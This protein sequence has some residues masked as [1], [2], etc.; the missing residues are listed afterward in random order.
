MIKA[1]IFDLDQTLIDS[2]IA[3]ANRKRRDWQTVYSQIPAFG[4]YDGFID[5]FD[6]ITN[7][8][9]RVCIITNSPGV[10]AK[11]VISHFQIPCDYLI[12]YHSV[13]RKK[14]H[15]EAFSKAQA[16]FD[17]SV[18][19]LLSFGDRAIDIEAS[20]AANINSVGCTWGSKELLSLKLS[21]PTYLIKSPLEIIE[22]IS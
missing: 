9:I 6:V 2:S 5:V 4:L 8:K 22:L 12:D 13:V 17:L 19:S 21:K 7:Q 1:V 11:K 16:F 14:P 10:Y 15:P 3:E 20:N 18:E